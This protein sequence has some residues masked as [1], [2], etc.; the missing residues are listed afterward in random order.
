MIG[1]KGAVGEESFD[2]NVC[3]PSWL[4]REVTNTGFVWGRHYLVVADYD[5]AR[6]KTIISSRVTACSGESWKQVGEK[7]SRIGYWEFEDY[8]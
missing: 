1:P 2:I 3:T 6:I 5:L 8:Q 7:L 4:S